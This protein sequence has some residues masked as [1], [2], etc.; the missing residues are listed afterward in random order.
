MTNSCNEDKAAKLWQD[1]T[2]GQEEAFWQKYNALLDTAPTEIPV[3]VA[4][5]PATFA[6]IGEDEKI[7]FTDGSFTYIILSVLKVMA[8][9]S[10][11]IYNFHDI[12]LAPETRSRTWTIAVVVLVVLVFFVRGALQGSAF[13]VTR[14]ALIVNKKTIPW[15]T[16]DYIHLKEEQRYDKEKKQYTFHYKLLIKT[17]QQEVQT[18]DYNLSKNEHHK[19]FDYLRVY[20]KQIKAAN[21]K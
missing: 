8:A 9:A 3:P 1:Y 5:Q 21:Y 13:E 11:I 18:F 14:L 15:Q 10:L 7:R 16:I 2:P 19:F 20:V 17:Q 6:H 12:L 4:I